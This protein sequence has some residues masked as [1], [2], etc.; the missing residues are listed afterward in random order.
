MLLIPC[1]LVTLV[2]STCIV[3]CVCVLLSLNISIGVADSFTTVVVDVD[4]AVA[5]G[6]GDAVEVA[7]AVAV[8]LGVGQVPQVPLTLKTMCMFAKPMVA[9]SVG[10]AIPQS[11]AL[12]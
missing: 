12:M 11:A 5:V 8:G 6:A 10:V 1:V 2:H 3:V 7:V 4:V 9:R